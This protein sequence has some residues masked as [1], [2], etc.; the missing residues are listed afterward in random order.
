MKI[1]TISPDNNDFLQV[2]LSIAKP[3]D[4]FYYMGEL[5]KTRVPSVAI[6]GTRKPSAYGREVTHKLAY[7]LARAGVTI[8][9]GLALGVDSIA[10]RAALEA[11]GRTIAVLGNGLPQIYPSSHKNLAEQI[12]NSGGVILTE[13]EEGRPALAHQF[14][15]RNRIVSGLS[16]AVIITEAALKSGTMSTATHARKQDKLLFAVPG[17]IT[18]PLSAG[19]NQLF[20]DGTARAVTDHSQIIDALELDKETTSQTS[21]PIGTTPEETKIIELLQ[22]GV[23]DTN[24][25]QK[26]SGI[27][28]AAFSTALTMLEINVVIKSVGVNRWILR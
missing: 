7:N 3:P 9:S 25:L 8:I 20:V 12:V 19:C 18:N 15:E 2:S 26:Q 11:G 17:P 10:H 1:N 6:V 28:A 4:M 13:Y 16:D 27:D 21:L 24:D 5:P 23:K 22:K 14:L